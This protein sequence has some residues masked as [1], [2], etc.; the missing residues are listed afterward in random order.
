[1]IEFLFS[2]AGLFLISLF[3]GFC[4]FIAVHL[5][6]FLYDRASKNPSSQNLTPSPAKPTLLNI[7]REET[8]SPSRR[9]ESPLILDTQGLVNIEDEEYESHFEFHVNPYLLIGFYELILHEKLNVNDKDFFV[10]MNYHMQ[11]S[12]FHDFFR[13]KKEE[14]PLF[15]EKLNQ[16]LQQMKKSPNQKKFLVKELYF[17]FKSPDHKSLHYEMD[18]PQARSLFR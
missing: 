4:Y 11:Q 8:A 17:L 13:I 16:I 12:Y 3:L 7:N 5:Y 15:D 2:Y 9:N 6:H 1:M 18:N 10:I 14:A